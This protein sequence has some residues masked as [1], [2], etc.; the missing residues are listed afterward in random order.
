MMIDNGWQGQ[1]DHQTKIIILTHH[2]QEF[3]YWRQF[4]DNV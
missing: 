2:M 1:E 4:G 3:W